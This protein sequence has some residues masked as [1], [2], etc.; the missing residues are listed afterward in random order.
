[1]L[2]REVDDTAVCTAG[3]AAEGVLADVEREAGVMV[4]VEGAE[5]LVAHNVHAEALS[6]AL[7]GEAAQFFDS[8]LV[9]GYFLF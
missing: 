3:E 7:D 5:G 8:I 6:D 9:H 1:M 2:H 4:R